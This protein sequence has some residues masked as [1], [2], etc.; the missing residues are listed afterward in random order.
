MAD[1]CP[2]CAHDGYVVTVVTVR[3]FGEDPKRI[4]VTRQCTGSGCHNKYPI[5]KEERELND[6]ERAL[7]RNP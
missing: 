6:E 7:W 3:T 5:L 4:L 2:R 1:S